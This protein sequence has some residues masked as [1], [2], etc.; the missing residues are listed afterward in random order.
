MQNMSLSHLAYELKDSEVLR[1]PIVFASPHSGRST[2]KSFCS[3][4]FWTRVIRSSEDAYVDQLIDFIPEM[5][6]PLLLAKVP[7]AYVDL[8]RAA[9]ELD[10]SLINDV[11]SRAQTRGSR[12]VWRSSRVVSNARAIYRG[13][14]SKPEALARIDQYWF[15]YH[16]ALQRLLSRACVFWL[17]VID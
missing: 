17:F 2:V 16:R 6:A 1:S 11:H 7:R 3:L 12:P 14:L 15:P 10:P 4:Q 9:D 5:G 13:K 8:N